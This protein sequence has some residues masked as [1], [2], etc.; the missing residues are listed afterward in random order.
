MGEVISRSLARLYDFQHSDGGWGWWKEGESDHFMTGY[1][2][3]GLQLADDAGIEVRRD[4]VRRAA[5]YLDREI[6]EAE[7]DLDLQAWMLHALA[8]HRQSS[9][10]S[11]TT[12]EEGAFDNMWRSRERLNAYGRALL[13]MSAHFMGKGREAS[14]LVENLENGAILDGNPSTSTFARSGSSATGS[15]LLATAHWGDDGVRWHWAQGGVEATSFV[16]T[17]FLLIDPEN[18][19]G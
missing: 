5:T 13:A 4:V 10:T 15:G 9:G 6:V 1:V 17:A 19:P 18:P 2:V 16:L 3:W 11:H 8:Y 7:S 14:V 12:L